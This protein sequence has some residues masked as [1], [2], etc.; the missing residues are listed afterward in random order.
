MLMK[1]SQF[2]EQQLHFIEKYECIIS[3]FNIMLKIN[4]IT[5]NIYLLAHH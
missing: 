1:Y 5:I 3:L 2:H 4:F